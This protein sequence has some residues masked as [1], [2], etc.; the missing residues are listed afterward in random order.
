M[1]I[2]IVGGGVMGFSIAK[3]IL[4]SKNNH[5]CAVVEHDNVRAGALEDL[6]I[7]VFP[8]VEKAIENSNWSVVEVCLLAV[9]PADIPSTSQQIKD[10]L[11][12]SSAILS[13]AAG[14]SISTLQDLFEGYGVVRAMPNIA[15]S[16]LESATAFCM[17]DEVTE[18]QLENSREVLSAFGS[19]IRVAEEEMNL[20]TAISGSGPA[21]FFYLA[22]LLVKAG[23][24]EGMDSQT[25][26][27]LVTQTFIGAAK[28]VSENPSFK[29]LRESVTS[30]GG[31]TA[32]ALGLFDSNG[33]AD[34]VSEAVQAAVERAK[35]LNSGDPGKG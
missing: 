23:I 21:Y 18:T 33:F 13:I 27:E 9:K 14:I 25:A 34:T 20:V 16:Q 6:G 7:E 32:A 15:A 12:G 29:S 8:S 28:M 19:T 24:A 17:A 22:E 4:H 2:L 5:V 11:P 35:E 26:Q 30:P 31:T 1:K 10:I 3:G